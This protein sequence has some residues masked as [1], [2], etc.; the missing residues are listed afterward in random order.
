MKTAC[1][2]RAFPNHAKAAK[3]VTRTRCC[4]RWWIW[5]WPTVTRSQ[6]PPQRRRE[7]LHPQQE[8]PPWQT[9]RLNSGKRKYRDPNR[10]FRNLKCTPKRKRAQRLRYSVRVN[11]VPDE[12]FKS[13]ISHIPREAEQKLI[14]ASSGALTRYHYRRAESSKIKLKKVEQRPN[15]TRRK[16]TNNLELIKNRPRPEKENRTDNVLVLATELL[17]NKIKKVEEMMKTL[18]DKESESY[19]CVFTDSLVKGREKEKRKIRNNRNHAQRSNRRRDTNMK[20]TEI[21]Q[22]YIKK[23]TLKNLSNCKMTT[24]QK[25]LLS[26]KGV[27]I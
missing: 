15:V 22:R 26:N 25:N 19:P 10:L 9:Q 20:N 16:K 13:D 12:Q 3:T 14:G 8:I 7:R 23:K 18:Q 21:N 6:T 1:L 11:I 2:C 24:D 5:K 27:K 4:I 17:T